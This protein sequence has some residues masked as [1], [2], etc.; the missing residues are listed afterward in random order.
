MTAKEKE[1]AMTIQHDKT[2]DFR[3]ILERKAKEL[4]QVLSHRDGII[5]EKSADQMDETQNSSARELAIQNADRESA[6]LRDVKAALQRIHDGSFGVCTM[7]DQ[8]ISSK[9]LAAVPSALRCISCQ[10]I[11]DQTGNQSWNPMMDG[12]LTAA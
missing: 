1:K 10:E 9:R 11:A 6:S 12:M 5:I 3:V 4:V 8:E 7:C 2:A